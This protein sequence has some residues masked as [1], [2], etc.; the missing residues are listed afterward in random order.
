M[1]LRATTTG[2]TVT[3]LVF[4]LA[5]MA[6][7]KGPA[8]GTLSGPGIDEP[9]EFLDPSHDFDD[10]TLSGGPTEMLRLSGLWY[11]PGRSPLPNPP[12]DPGPAHTLTWFVMVPSGDSIEA[13]EIV[14]EARSI[15]QHIYLEAEEGPLIHT[16]DQVGLKGW[17]DSVKGW[18]EAPEGLE[19]AIG[20]IVASN[21]AGTTASARPWL[22]PAIVVAA[23]AGLAG[24]GRRLSY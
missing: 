22:L 14:I 1:R 4:G 6:G 11:G 24:F 3:A 7:A 15:V 10:S 9:I 8:S 21:E 16:P 2:L 17:G 20:R 12:T 19:E 18:F 13:G 5:V 23:V